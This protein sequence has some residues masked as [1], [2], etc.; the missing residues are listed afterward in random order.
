MASQPPHTPAVTETNTLLVDNV[1]D[2][3]DPQ[4]LTLLLEDNCY[5]TRNGGPIDFMERVGKGQYM[6][7][8]T[9]STG[10]V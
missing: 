3:A 8:F 6:V 1:P 10:Q 7:C 2:D 5:R 4:S 9:S